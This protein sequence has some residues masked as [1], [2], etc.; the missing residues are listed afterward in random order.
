M[1][2]NHMKSIA[3]PKTWQV[4]RKAEVFVSRPNSG[5]HKLSLGVSLIVFFK[6]MIK[7]CKT[8]KEV[9]NVI[10]LKGVLVNGKKVDDKNY[11]VGL[12]DVV[13]I[14]ATKQSYRIY[15]SDKGKLVASLISG[16]DADVVPARIIQKTIIRQG[17]LQ[18]NFSNGY[19]MIGE[20]GVYSVGDT[21]LFEVPK[22]K[23]K[24]HIK[25]EKGAYVQIIAGKY[26]GLQ[27]EVVDII[28]YE[29]S[30]GDL[31]VFRLEDGRELSTLKAYAFALGKK[32][33]VILLGE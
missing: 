12:Y 14:E 21:V 27:G 33:P 3:A 11:N 18:L 16:K 31:I 23:I 9:S 19:N 26:L 24:E 13:A 32:K 25:F 7:V 22:L 5:S 20:R 8:T 1:V 2:K 29:S 28:R 30:N 17:L 15:L 4:D 6:T 10:Y